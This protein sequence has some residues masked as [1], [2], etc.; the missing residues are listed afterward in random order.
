MQSKWLSGKKVDL[1]SFLTHI[2]EVEA[3]ATHPVDHHAVMS[4]HTC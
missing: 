2:Q 1:D 4:S 3:A